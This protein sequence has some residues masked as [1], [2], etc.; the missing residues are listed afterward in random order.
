MFLGL[1]NTGVGCYLY[2]SSIGGLPA[3]TVAVCG[4]LEPLSAVA[5]SVVLLGEVLM[6]IQL[7][8]MILI[9]GGAAAGELLGKGRVRR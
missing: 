9:I 1:I 4:Y 8:G 5:F 3:Q 2:F 7:V 6:P